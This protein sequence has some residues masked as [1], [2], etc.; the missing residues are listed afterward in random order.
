M[1]E[2]LREIGKSDTYKYLQHYFDESLCSTVEL[3]GNCAAMIKDNNFETFDEWQSY[4]MLNNGKS[5]SEAVA[6]LRKT[7]EEKYQTE[8]TTEEYM[9]CLLY[10]ILCQTWDGL[11]KE[12]EILNYLQNMRPN[13]HFRLSTYKEDKNL[14]IDILQFNKENKKLERVFQIKPKS[15]KKIRNTKY[16]L[17]TPKLKKFYEK[18]K[19]EVWFI[20]YDKENDKLE[21]ERIY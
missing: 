13:L 9:C 16:D 12:K 19:K 17:Q 5:L 14:G 1:E 6:R 20:F 7:I 15:F 10:H 4:W 18:Y 3:V 21:Y 2:L 11:Q 8:F